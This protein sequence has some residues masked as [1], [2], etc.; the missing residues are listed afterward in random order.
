MLLLLLL[1]PLLFLFILIIIFVINNSNAT[2]EETPL[3]PI[4]PEPDYEHDIDPEPD[5]E[6]DIDPEPEHDEKFSCRDKF[7]GF[8]P[9]LTK[10]NTFYFC[11][12]NFEQDDNKILK[13]Y[14][15]E[16]HEFNYEEQKCVIISENG[17]TANK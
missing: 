1:L 3:P 12:T 8:Y 17:C 9:H 7:I 4:D 16:N 10:C 2:E 14:C 13:L 15:P 5:Y 6:H 11:S